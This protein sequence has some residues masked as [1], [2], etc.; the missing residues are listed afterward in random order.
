MGSVPAEEEFVPGKDPL[1]LAPPDLLR[2]YA[3][4]AARVNQELPALIIR[5]DT[6]HGIA[7]GAHGIA[8]KLREDLTELIRRV[9][10]IAVAVKAK[11]RTASL[12]PPSTD[13][14]EFNFMPTKTGTHFQVESS[15]IERL[16]AQWAE[17]EARERGAREYA[18]ELERK[19]ELRRKA[20]ESK[21]NFYL[22]ILALVAAVASVTTYSIEHI[23][24]H[25]SKIEVKP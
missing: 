19:E 8:S 21:R 25:A 11:P 4:I 2:A 20:S 12:P 17:K 1:P 6:I 24:V 7:L 5:V 22:F 3:N 15:E 16:K 14:F 23:S 9:E 13:K 18:L 10:D